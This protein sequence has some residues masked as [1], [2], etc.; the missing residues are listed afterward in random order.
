[1]KIIHKLRFL[2]LNEYLDRKKK[3]KENAERQP[4]MVA[5]RCVPCCCVPVLGCVVMGRF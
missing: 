2:K 5:S 4:Y 3:R 1:M